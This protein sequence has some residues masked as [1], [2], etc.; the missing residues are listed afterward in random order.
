MTNVQVFLRNR[1]LSSYSNT[2]RL[3]IHLVLALT[4]S[5]CISFVV[6]PQQLVILFRLAFGVFLNRSTTELRNDRV[7]K[8]SG[9]LGHTKGDKQQ[10]QMNVCA[11]LA[12]IYSSSQEPT[13]TKLRRAPDEVFEDTRCARM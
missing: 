1:K 6:H 3:G 12:D 4:E 13:A 9:N 8:I 10:P 11:S 5:A 7:V 2:L